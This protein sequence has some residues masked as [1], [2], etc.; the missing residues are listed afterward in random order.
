MEVCVCSSAIIGVGGAEIEKVGKLS[1]IL[2]AKKIYYDYRIVAHPCLTEGD[3][4]LDV[5]LVLARSD[6]L[7]AL[8]RYLAFDLRAVG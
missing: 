3:L 2:V 1:S 4:R 6:E 7:P 5:L 8:R